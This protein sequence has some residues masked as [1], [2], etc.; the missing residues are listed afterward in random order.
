M[1]FGYVKGI[2]HEQAK[3]HAIATARVVA[4]QKAL[5][6]RLASNAAAA[7]RQAA[8]NKEITKG[9]D[10]ENARLN[11]RVGALGRLGHGAGICGGPAATTE[12]TGASSGDSTNTSGGLVREDV[13]RDLKSLIIAVETD[14]AIGRTCQAFL[15]K[16]GLIP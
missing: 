14:V 5:L 2:S 6:T 12:A 15:A 4:T 8:T 13:A 3:Q 10:D 1:A 11:A 7:T 16:N 9:K